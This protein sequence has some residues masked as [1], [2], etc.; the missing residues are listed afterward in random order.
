MSRIKQRYPGYLLEGTWSV[1]HL[2]YN[3]KSF[4]QRDTWNSSIIY[5]SWI[6]L[7][8]HFFVIIP[9][10]RCNIY[11]VWFCFS[12]NMWATE[13]SENNGYSKFVVIKIEMNG[14]GASNWDFVWKSDAHHFAEWT[15][16]TNCHRLS[17]SLYI[18]IGKYLTL[19]NAVKYVYLVC[20]SSFYEV[21]NSMRWTLYKYLWT[22]QKSRKQ[23]DS[24]N[25][26]YME[27]LCFMGKIIIPPKR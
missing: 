9:E 22:K 15:Y 27:Y 2:F 7:L 26:K 11:K 1:R 24:E 23:S 4:I 8:Y 16:C 19:A 10:Q 13:E 21:Q 12:W 25:G 20:S 18:A 6:I 17:Y 5:L 14:I 3:Q